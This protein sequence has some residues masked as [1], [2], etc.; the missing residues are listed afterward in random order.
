M[1]DGEGE[2]TRAL[3]GELVAWVRRWR[4]ELTGRGADPEL[5]AFCLG[6]MVERMAQLLFFIGIG[7]PSEEE[8]IQGLNRVWEAVLGLQPETTT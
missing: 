4:P 2:D 1:P 5:T 6:A 8:L 7:Q 3:R